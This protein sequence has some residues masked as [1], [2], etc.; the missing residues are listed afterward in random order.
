MAKAYR[1]AV[2]RPQAPAVAS[3]SV[4]QQ[5]AK[6]EHR[7]GALRERRGSAGRTS[8]RYPGVRPQRLD[9]SPLARSRQVVLQAQVDRRESQRAEGSPPVPAPGNAARSVNGP[10]GNGRPPPAGDALLRSI[11]VS[12]GP[13]SRVPAGRRWL[14]GEFR[15]L[16]SSHLWNPD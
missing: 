16:K 13:F 4:H 1:A 8:S 7:G 10:R 2:S 5:S 15:L 14:F 12:A 9:E 6:P 3:L 11:A